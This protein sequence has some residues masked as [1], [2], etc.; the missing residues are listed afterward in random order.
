MLIQTPKLHHTFWPHTLGGIF[1][2]FH[3]VDE[4]AIC[5]PYHKRFVF[6]GH[7]LVYRIVYGVLQGIL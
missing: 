1:G 2:L 5:P 4:I 3:S 7:T 6:L